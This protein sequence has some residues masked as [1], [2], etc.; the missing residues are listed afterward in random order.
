MENRRVLID[1]S[2]MI[3]HLRRQKK[4]RTIF[5]EIAG[6]NGCYISSITE[7]EF[8]V[9]TTPKNREFTNKLLKK[10]TVL[11]FD[12]DC[13]RIAIDIYHNLKSKNKLITL[14]DIF[15]AATAVSNQLPLATLNVKHFE[16]IDRLQLH[17]K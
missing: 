13:V 12:S 15:I 1:T 4:D 6:N 17:S 2:I 10:L 8:S 16:N 3:D 14:P 5:Y 9:G 7:F 11:Q